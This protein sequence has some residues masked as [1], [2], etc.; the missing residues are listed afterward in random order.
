MPRKTS[1]PLELREARAA[2]AN[3]PA[4]GEIGERTRRPYVKEVHFL[5]ST[6]FTPLH[7]VV[8]DCLAMA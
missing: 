8:M 7:L 2:K 6:Q 3:P 5:R 4:P 1:S